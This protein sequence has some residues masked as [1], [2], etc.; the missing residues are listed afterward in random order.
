MYTFLEIFDEIEDLRKALDTSDQITVN[1]IP[2]SYLNTNEFR[3]EYPEAHIHEYGIIIK[4][5]IKNSNEE[6]SIHT[7]SWEFLEECLKRCNLLS[8]RF[9]TEDD[10]DK[11]K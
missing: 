3:V 7:I 1:L 6:I 4:G 5:F 9:I 10:T 8:V 11:S 2:E